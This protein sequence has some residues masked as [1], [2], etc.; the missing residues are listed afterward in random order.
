[1][2][3][4]GGGVSVN[5]RRHQDAAG[6]CS[7]CWYSRS[8][9]AT[10]FS[11]ARSLTNPGRARSDSYRCFGVSGACESFMRVSIL[12]QF[13]Q[14]AVLLQRLGIGERVGVF[15]RP[16]VDHVAHRELG[17]LAA[18]GARDVGHREDLGGHVARRGVV[19]DRGFDFLDKRVIEPCAFAQTHEQDYAYVALPVLA[20]REALDD[21][22]EL[23]HLSI[24]FRGAD[25]HAAGIERGIRA[26]VD[27]ETVALREF[28][29]VAVTPDSGEIIEIGGVVFPAVR[30]VPEMHRHAREGFHAHQFPRPAAYGLAVLVPDFYRHAEATAL[31]FAWIHRQQ[32]IAEGETRNDV[33]AAGNRGQAQLR[34]D[35]AVN[36]FGI[37]GQQGRAGGG[38]DTQLVEFVFFL[39]PDAEFLRGR[40]VL[41]AGAENAD[42]FR[43]G[44]APQDVMM[45]MEWRAVVE[46]HACAHRQTRHQPVPHHP[47]AGGVIKNHVLALE[48]GV[49]HQL[50][51]MLNQRAAGAVHDALRHPGSAGAVHDVNRM[52]EGQLR[53][54]DL[55]RVSQVIAP[56]DR[57]RQAGDVRF[58]L[59]VRH[60]HHV[61]DRGQFF[62]HAADALQRVH[63]LAGIEI[64]VAGEQHLGLDLA[65]TVKHA[66]DAEVRRTGG[67]DGTDTGRRE[68]GN[69]G[70]WAVG[71]EARDA[72]A[73]LYSGF[74]QGIRE[75]GDLAIEF[76]VSIGNA[77]MF[78]FAAKY[79]R[80]SFVAVAQQV[81]GEVKAR[82]RK[83]L[84][85]RHPV[86]V[87]E[88][89]V[90]GLR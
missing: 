34:F 7:R 48:V 39:R 61:L 41:G 38:D 74:F 70:F 59:D 79:Q 1:M 49:Q 23:F 24:D 53:E 18:D 32:R 27:D 11:C 35:V 83:P 75:S 77:Q 90:P 19:A 14:V 5:S 9:A 66:V 36:V 84:G 45:R 63:G 13:R 15:H 88:H 43:Y 10:A 89:L 21:F 81:L 6:R 58:L 17:D 67:P 37:L 54:F 65:E 47:A 46:Q 31:E 85:S 76:L 4:S 22:R 78:V 69:D 72:I 71:H 44:D 40:Q 73:W 86:A 60:H 57:M 68:H 30:V 20:D 80:R 16:P 64:A 82:A 62:Q 55:A 33:G 26:A 56:V 52:I 8:S 2:P 25:A 51:E 29:P 3:L 12:L 87:R 28:R 42:A 50:L